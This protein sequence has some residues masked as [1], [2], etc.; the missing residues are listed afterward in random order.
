MLRGVTKPQTSVLLALAALSLVVGIGA[1]W[2]ATDDSATSPSEA[3]SGLPAEDVP[4]SAI[5]LG[6][7]DP[8]PAFDETW[9]ELSPEAV[10]N[11]PDCDLVAGRGA[12]QRTA[13]VL[14]PWSEHEA[15]YVVVDEDGVR[16]GGDLPFTFGSF[17]DVHVAVGKRP[18][19]STIAALRSFRDGSVEV[20]HDGQTIYRGADTWDFDLAPDGSSFVAVEPLAGGSRLVL[21]NLD[22]GAEYHHD[23][24]DSISDRGASMG[25]RG[26]VQYAW[27]S[28]THTEVIVNPNGVGGGTYRFYPVDGSH[29]REVRTD[30]ELD[31]LRIDIFHSSELSYHVRFNDEG[32]IRLHREERQFQ[33]DG[34]AHRSTEVWFR[35]FPPQDL[36][37]QPLVSEDGAWVVVGLET[38]G[39]AL[40]ASSGDTVV[41]VPFD[42]QAL[43]RHGVPTGV[44]FL[45]GRIA[46]YRYLHGGESERDQRFVEV[47]DLM[48]PDVQG[49]P[50]ARTP[51][52]SAPHARIA[53]FGHWL[54]ENGKA[55]LGYN[56]HD[57]DSETPCA[58][59]VRSDDRVLVADGDRLTY[60]I[61]AQPA[62]R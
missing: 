47:Y 24:E 4:A 15:W 53:G 42:E 14:I 35:E 12:A 21:R 20:V 32:T 8:E 27:Y 6:G 61:R 16:F 62:W 7:A 29:P 9:Y 56:R 10:I 30:G 11:R 23:L 60:R 49:R 59:P 48:E 43:R 36:W 55:E 38:L 41:S 5:T 25:W 17:R 2:F 58:L 51:I 22:S 26:F 18:D 13:V 57:V 44:H 1:W 37:T 31:D 39:V 3:P 52:E 50:S 46:L 54:V 33:G 34:K 45:G 19:G 40:D 28:A